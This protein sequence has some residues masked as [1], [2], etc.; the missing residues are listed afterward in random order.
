MVSIPPI[1]NDVTA[2]RKQSGIIQQ[3]GITL[4]LDLLDTKKEAY[5]LDVENGTNQIG[6][7][8]FRL[9]NGANDTVNFFLGQPLAETPTV[10]DVIDN[11]RQHFLRLMIG[12]NLDVRRAVAERPDMESQINAGLQNRRAAGESLVQVI[13]NAVNADKDTRTA[14]DSYLIEARNL[15]I[16]AVEQAT[17][18]AVSG[19][20]ENIARL[21]NGLSEFV[22]DA[23][24]SRPRRTGDG[25]RVSKEIHEFEYVSSTFI[26][27]Y[28]FE[29]LGEV[30]E[31][32]F[33]H[34]D[35]ALILIKLNIDRGINGEAGLGPGID[36]LS[37]NFA[38]NYGDTLDDAPGN[39]YRRDRFSF[40][41]FVDSYHMRKLLAELKKLVQSTRAD[42]VL[43]AL[44][45]SGG[46]RQDFINTVLSEKPPQF[47]V[48]AA[49]ELLINFSENPRKPVR[50]V[51]D[52]T[53][54]VQVFLPENNA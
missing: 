44:R 10:Q 12:T 54:M 45:Q 27:T 48:A 42:N 18:S 19:L 32:G 46:S 1:N 4:F 30:R 47:V 11:P 14:F 49:N 17:V 33:T 3:I 22:I 26:K 25:K 34:L 16:E 29:M 13:A 52:S 9:A 23:A 37:S 51:I 5:F 38:N 40:G 43:D 6:A 31:E 41:N 36:F 7:L 8:A 28:G 24:F 39:L 20:D 50:E 35:V 15:A 53:E 2:R 21:V